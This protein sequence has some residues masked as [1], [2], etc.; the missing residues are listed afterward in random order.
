MEF[1]KAHQE[2][3]LALLAVCLPILLPAVNR[4][5]AFLTGNRYVKNGLIIAKALEDG[6]QPNELENLIAGIKLNNAAKA[7]QALEE[8]A[9]NN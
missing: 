1:L 2:T 5:L 8:A 4:R 3:I 7:G 9:E 6:I